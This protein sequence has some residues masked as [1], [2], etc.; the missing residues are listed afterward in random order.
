M[1][2]PIPEQHGVGFVSQERLPQYATRY[3][4]EQVGRYWN[5]HFTAD[6]FEWPEPVTCDAPVVLDGFS[7]NLNKTLHVGHL[8]NL[9]LANSL[10]RLT[11]IH[12]DGGGLV[13]LLGASQGVLSTAVDDFKRWCSF[14][15][16]TPRVYYD[17]LQPW[18]YVDCH[19]VEDEGNPARGC[20][21]WHGPQ[22]PVI[23]VR[24]DGRP[25][26]SFYDLAFAKAVGPTHYLTGAEQSPHF[27]ALGMPEK[28]LPM[29]LVLG[30]DGKKMKSR[31][32]DSPT[33]DAVLGEIKANLKETPEPDKLAWNVA[34][35]NFL[36]V[37]RTQNVRFDAARWT[38]VN[39]GGMYVSYTAARL[40][41]AFLEVIPSPAKRQF[42]DAD[43][44]LLGVAAYVDHYIQRSLL[45][46]DPAPL[47]GYA[48]LLARKL[49]VAYHREPIRNG[50]PAFQFAVAEGLDTLNA[51][52]TQLGMFVLEKV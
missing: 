10:A 25:T 39:G 52:L 28:H 33:A 44:A 49:G 36:H 34:A 7:P 15:N 51:C 29:G 2:R 40:N 1:I 16:Y 18:D 35:W 19:L 43:V 46:M 42:T 47:A 32:G 31:T 9:A 13:A 37:G 50:R 27:A 12:S 8:R 22:G 45:T 6:C 30:S 38:D 17:V 48:L 20:K 14:L 11:D 3:R 5:Y 26:Y 4:E 21:V 23:V 41:S 24:S